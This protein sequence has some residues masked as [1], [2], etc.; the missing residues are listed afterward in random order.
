MRHI[1]ALISAQSAPEANFRLNPQKCQN[2]SNCVELSKYLKKLRLPSGSNPKTCATPSTPRISQNA[3]NLRAPQI[4]RGRLWCRGSHVLAHT[5]AAPHFFARHD[6]VQPPL[7]ARGGGGAELR[8]GHREGAINRY[9]S[10]R[11]RR[12][13]QSERACPSM[14]LVSIS[15]GRH[16]RHLT[17][18]SLRYLTP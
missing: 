3:S 14:L 10:R 16:W 17:A 1:D 2:P 13:A 9:R 4:P 18:R 7:G 11:Q 5:R 8:T 6:N 15:L 12:R